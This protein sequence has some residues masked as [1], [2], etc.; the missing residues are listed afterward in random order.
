M[1][2]DEAVHTVKFHE[3]Y[4]KG[5]YRY[6][7]NEY[8]GP[9]I[10][11]AALPVIAL[12]GR[13]DFAHTQA[14]DYRLVTALFGVAMVALLFLLTDAIG[15]Q[16]TVISALF[17]ALSPAFGFY[18]RY[19]IQETPFA[20]FTL[21]W[22]VCR[23]RYMQ[24][25]ALA[26]SILGGICAGLMLASKETAALTFAA[27]LIAVIITR[28]I[29]ALGPWNG[30][31]TRNTLISVGVAAV[32]A[33]FVVSGF[34][35]SVLAPV[36][37]LRSYFAWT[38]RAGVASLHRQPALYF[39][40]LLFGPHWQR[41]GTFYSEG[42]ILLL[43]VVGMI[44]SS[45]DRTRMPSLP[46]VFVRFLTL[47]TLALTLIYSVIPYKTPWCLLSFHLGFCILAGVGTVEIWNRAR[48]TVVRALLVCLFLAGL[49]NLGWQS[50]RVNFIAFADPRNPYVYSPTA[51]E[52]DELTERLTALSQL[53]PEHDQMTINVFSVDEY[54]WPL[55]WY[56]RRF[57]KVG[58][59]TQKLPSDIEAPIILSSP[60][61]D[62]E[63]TRRLDKTHLMTGFYGLRSGVLI[64]LWV[65]L[66][67]WERFIKAQKASS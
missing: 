25:P 29:P 26:W 61:F 50:Y 2:A 4:E 49:A 32:V 46:L 52:I 65:R 43:A 38:S 59:W 28:V 35:S 15:W 6:D 12:R 45:V 21:G 51:P 27:A 13:S 63:L 18:S 33:T 7:A 55:P 5:N 11:Y 67:L 19:Y 44:A 54:Y 56:L 48:Q 53:S 23:W 37:Y 1:H 10:Y 60:T 22:I 34:G 17:L 41:G 62:E 14:S 8:H 24:K 16:A 47:Y 36:D 39:L 31:H 20:F 42:M 57:S 64:Q 66:D 9:T 40:S 3:L 30:G 58:Y